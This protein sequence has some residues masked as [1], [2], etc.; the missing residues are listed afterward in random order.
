MD[1]SNSMTG[2]LSFYLVVFL[3]YILLCSM[4]SGTYVKTFSDKKVIEDVTKRVREFA[5][6]QGRRPRLL[7]AKM[8][9]DGH[10]RGTS[11]LLL[12]A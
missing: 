2:N 1:V 10:D 4:I 11:P 8:G 6:Q 5:D 9:Q 3:I 12:H 7:V